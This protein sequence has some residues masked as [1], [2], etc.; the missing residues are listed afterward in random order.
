MKSVGMQ[1]LGAIRKL[2]SENFTPKRT[3][4]ITFGP[5]EELGGAE[6]MKV[7]VES[8]DFK[9]LNIGFSLDEGIA[10]PTEVFPVFYAERTVRRKLLKNN[11]FQI[12]YPVYGIILGLLF[13]INGSPGHGS[14]LLENTAGVKVNYILNK[15][16]EMREFQVKMLENNPE[17]TTGDVTSINLTQIFGGVQSNVIPP[18]FTLGFD[19]RFS[20]NIDID[21]FDLQVCTN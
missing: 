4:H 12:F 18:Q 11:H 21:E 7:F 5:D 15:M 10:S 8:D 19:I 9:N 1:Y 3:I 14:L 16:S 17:L 13:K 20:L 6:G 2:K